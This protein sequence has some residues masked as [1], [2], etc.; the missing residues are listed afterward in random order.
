MRELAHLEG[1]DGRPHLLI[2][3]LRDVAGRAR[4]V[5]D[6]VDTDRG[7]LGP[8]AEWAGWLHDLGKYRVEF[9]D[10]LA[11]RR[12]KSEETQ[13]SVFGAAAARGSGLPI[14]ISFYTKYSDQ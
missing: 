12:E 4:Q 11:K 10:Y 8:M 3:H 2:D 9:Q 1:A 7:P 5:A 14:A 6:S 13:H